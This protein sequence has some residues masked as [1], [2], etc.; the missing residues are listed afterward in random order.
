MINIIPHYSYNGFTFLNPYSIFCLLANAI[1]AWL[2]GLDVDNCSKFE[3]NIKYSETKSGFIDIALTEEEQKCLL[4]VNTSENTKERVFLLSKDEAGNQ[5]YFNASDDSNE[6]NSSNKR[7]AFLAGYAYQTMNS[8]NSFGY[9][10]ECSV[11]KCTG[12][13]WLRD[14]ISKCTQSAYNN[15]YCAAYVN[16]NGDIVEENSN[17]SALFL[18]FA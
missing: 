1:R 18:T 13:Y 12:P 8:A 16:S 14:D 3:D 2:N 5:E 9:E 15:L 10:D 11:G 17:Y 6:D 4:E 7:R